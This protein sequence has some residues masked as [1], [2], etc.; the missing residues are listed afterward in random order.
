VTGDWEITLCKSQEEVSQYRET[1]CTD[2][3]TEEEKHLTE[4]N[5]RISVGLAHGV[6]QERGNRLSG[7]N[8][9]TTIEFCDDGRLEKAESQM[10]Q[11]EYGLRTVQETGGRMLGLANYLQI[12]R[13]SPL[14]KVGKKLLESKK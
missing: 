7:G 4:I 10:A 2:K 8:E 1:H 6:G 3:S 9:D 14:R 5:D 11:S 13:K 12:S